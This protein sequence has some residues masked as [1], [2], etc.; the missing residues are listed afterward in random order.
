MPTHQTITALPKLPP[1]APDSH[2][3][4]YGAVLIVAGS[5][6]MS[7]AAV[8]CGAGALRGGAGLVRVATP[9]DVQPLVAA[10]NPC[11]LTDGLPIEVA[12]HGLAED[13]APLILELAES[14][15]VVAIGPGLGRQGKIVEIIELVTARLIRP[16][17]IDADALNAL[18][19]LPV[20]ALKRREAPT[21]LTPH[22]GEF[23]RLLK[24]STSE[25]QAHR[26]ELALKFAT[27]R[28][29]VLL[30]K[31]HETIVTDG[32][33][34]YTNTTGNPGMATGGAGDVLTGLIAA[35]IAQGLAP[36]EAAQFGAYLHGKAGDLAV[37]KTGH[38]SLIASDLLDFL[39]AAFGSMK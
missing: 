3:G 38:V 16:M 19:S 9:T 24:V 6:G 8:L 21:V 17:V 10:G 37:E 23:G 26:Q 28:N 2:K 13:A 34:L 4:T 29:V 33:R 20:D 39:P 1:R 32:Q 27:E 5:R 30:L 12:R 25:V 7:G 31:G 14:A 35:L 36:F 22:P 15:D 18:A 11:Y